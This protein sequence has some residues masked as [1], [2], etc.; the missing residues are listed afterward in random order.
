MS[1]TDRRRVTAKEKRDGARI[2][3]ILGILRR[4]GMM[5][6]LT[7]EKLCAVLEAL[8]PT[9]IKLG[10]LMSTRSD[11]LPAAYC[12]ALEKLRSQVSP[13]PLPE[14]HAVIEQAY[15]TPLSA[16][17]TSFQEVPEGSASI[18]QVHLATLLDGT[19]VAVKVQRSGLRETMGRDMGLL[20]RAAKLLNR[21]NVAGGALD[22]RML[23]REMW[24]AAQQEM[25]FVQEADHLE[26]F[27]ARN[28]DI[29]Y[30]ACPRVFRQYTTPLVLVMEWVDGLA[31]DNLPALR[32]AGYDLEDIS[33]KLAENFAKQVLDDAFFHADPHAGNLR[34]RDGRIVWLDLGM[35]GRLSARDKTL[36]QHAVV[37]F[38]QGD[39]N[40]VKDVLLTLGVSSGPVQH[41]RLYADL[42]DF[43]T[44]YGS[45]GVQEM[46]LGELLEELLALANAHHI[47]LP[48]GLSMLGRS[49]SILQSLLAKLNPDLNLLAV[50]S[51]HL[52]RDGLG[53][54]SL[55]DRLEEGGR[56]LLASGQKALD[57]PAQVSDL[58]KATVKGQ[59]RLNLDLMGAE[60]P[61]RRIEQ[62]TG[63]LV[64]AVLIA[65]LLLSGSLLLGLAAGQ[66]MALLGGACYALAVW[67]GI[68]LWWS[69]R[70][71]KK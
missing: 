6:G 61:L 21:S 60:E 1:K 31:M 44:R 67:L 12:R 5:K 35:M 28:A 71:A 27:A 70:K 52:R 46:N 47:A 25:D 29:S 59:T 40:G 11:I 54:R 43:L 58:L 64:L 15:G 23:L 50:L 10:Q 18:A 16:V 32:K 66:G 39:V 30:V 65:A 4:Q 51:G 26:E 37:A 41:V 20:M 3:E 57:I 8:G 36:L 34:V 69:A 49:I 56:S 45:M 22:F 48:G 63:R 24:Q 68:R 2:L 62:M 55:A 53:K 33:R 7:P 38:V 14:I 42:D 19:A 13:A 17:F 9:Y